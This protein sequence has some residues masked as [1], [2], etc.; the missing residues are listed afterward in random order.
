VRNQPHAISRAYVETVKYLA[1]NDL[2]AE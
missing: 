2:L 1:P